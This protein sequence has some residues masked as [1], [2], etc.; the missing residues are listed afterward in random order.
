MI[1]IA[2]LYSNELALYGEN[3]NIKALIYA[4]EKENIKYKLIQV[5][6]E[7]KLDFSKYNFV[8]LGSGRAKYLEEIKKRLLPYKDEILE[9]IENDNILLATGK[10]YDVDATT[11]LCKGNIKGFQNTEYLIKTTKNIMF[12]INNGVGNNETMM[13]GFQYKNLYATSIIGPLLARNDNLNQ[14]F[15]EIIKQKLKS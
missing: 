3:G 15:I 13:E 6:K 9:Y 7:D 1:T 2:T 8:Y 11:S 12:N 10:V 5:E 14:Y 4:L